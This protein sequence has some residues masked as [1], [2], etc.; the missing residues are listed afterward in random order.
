VP[1]FEGCRAY[2]D[3]PTKSEERD[4]PERS[5]RDICGWFDGV[6]FDEAEQGV[7]GKF[8][9]LESADWLRRTLKSAWDAGKRDLLGFSINAL[10]RMGARRGGPALVEAVEKVI[11]TDV[12]TTPGA[13]GRLLG[14]LESQ[15]PVE[16]QMDNEEQAAPA[17]ESPPAFDPAA[18]TAEVNTKFEALTT[19]IESL[20]ANVGSQ[21][22]TKED[23]DGD[24]G[25]LAREPSHE[26]PDG[27]GTPKRDDEEKR[28]QEAVD[29]RVRPV[30]LAQRKV[31]IAARVAAAKLPAKHAERLTAR[32]CEAAGRRE[33]EDAEVD[34]AVADLRETIADGAPARPAW[35]GAVMESGRS[36]VDSFARGVDGYF[37]GK[38]IEGVKA[39]PSIRHMALA[40]MNEFSRKPVD[41]LAINARVIMESLHAAQGYDSELHATEG[42]GTRLTESLTTS[43]WGDVFADVLYKNMLREY[44]ADSKYNDWRAVV[45]D[46]INVPDFQ[47]QRFVRTGGYA[48]LSVVAEGQTYPLATSPTDEAVSFAVQ[49]RGVIEDITFEMLQDRAAEQKI[50][51]IPLKL[52]RAAKRSLYKFVY[53]DLIASNPTMDYDTTALFDSSGHANTDTSAGLA[54]GTMQ[55][56]RQKMRDQTAYNESSE[57]LGELNEP[58][59]LLVPNEL[60]GL[61][62]RLTIRNEAYY[63]AIAS[64]TNTDTALDPNLF[65]GRLMAKTIDVWTDAND[66]IL[67]A[68]PS[69]VHTV[70]MGFL[71]GREEP[72]L[73]VQDNPTVGSVFTADKISYKIRAIWGGDVV[74]HRSF[75][76]GQG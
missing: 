6:H 52:A 5:I 34:Q 1:L 17:T 39:F 15:R 7:R 60:Q 14:V 13:G 76:R 35:E 45:S 54:V 37:Q 31:D 33:V 27:D 8:H 24:R 62:D 21:M 49:K 73:F 56:G 23:P 75:Y 50:R 57:V 44:S 22:P 70:V 46:V 9:V 2:C 11:S 41:P 55:T 30:L 36:F 20:R 25:R 3:H 42:Y 58:A 12:V 65:R 26:D 43:S 38:D 40:W 51:S 32:L 59:L 67:V 18:F 28:I 53:N 69:Q 64:N 68:D 63:A 72:E 48:D 47:I 10:G 19:L 29:A 66:W 61:A 71:N 4:R 74:D 16:G